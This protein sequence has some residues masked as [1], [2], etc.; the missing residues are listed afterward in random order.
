MTVTLDAFTEYTD[1]YLNW[2]ND[3]E[4]NRYT[5]RGA[6]P[7]TEAEARRYV[8]TCQSPERI[9]LAILLNYK[10]HN[11]THIGNI[12]LQKIDMLNRSAELAILIGSKNLQRKGYGLAAAKIICQHGFKQLGLNRIY[13]GTH[14]DNIGMQKLAEKLGMKKEGQ[15][16]QAF[17]KNGKFADIIHYGLLKEEFIRADLSL[18]DGS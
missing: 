6:Y 17:F 10:S 8:E 16:R 1:Q 14:Q 15:S 9:V 11:A 3:P 5:S 7:V 13:C 18:I 2:L 12:S 4:V